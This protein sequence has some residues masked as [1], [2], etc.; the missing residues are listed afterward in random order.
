[1]ALSLAGSPAQAQSFTVS[2]GDTVGQQIMGGVGDSGHVQLGGQIQT[3]GI[4]ETAVEMLASGQSLLN[5]GTISTTGDNALGIASNMDNVTITNRGTISTTG[6]NAAGIISNGTNA[7][8]G[9]SGTISTTGS[10]AVGII[11]VDDDVLIENGG[12]ISTTGFSALGIRSSG[13]DATLANSGAISTTGTLAD[14]ISS[15]GANAAITN[16]DTIT[17]TGDGSDGINSTGADAV[18]TNSGEISTAGIGAAGI[19]SSLGGTGATITNSGEISTTGDGG[20]GISSGAADAAIRNSGTITTTGS[21]AG[22]IT[23][24]VDAAN[25]VIENSGT[26]STTG[27]FAYGISSTGINATITSSGSISTTA[28]AVHSIR[29]AGADAVIE[30][31]GTISTSGMGAHGIDSVAP[32]AAITNSGTI[33]TTGDFSYALHSLGNNAAITNSGTLLTHGITAHGIVSDGDNT[34]ISN[35]G[36]LST[37]ADGA[38]AIL[39][40]GANTL[41]EN[42][43]TVSTTADGA[44]ALVSNNSDVVIRNSGTIST[45]G[46]NTDAIA[47]IGIDAVIVN[48]G[49]ISA[50]GVNSYAVWASGANAV[51]T[52][53]GTIT[54]EQSFSIGMTGQN[55]T[56]NL[57]RGSVLR[58]DIQFFNLGSATLNIGPGLSTALQLD[59]TPATITTSGMPFAVTVDAIY[60]ADVTA[61]GSEGEALADL[62]GGIFSAIGGRR[63]G[64]SAAVPLAYAPEKAPQTAIFRTDDAVPT[65]EAWLKGFGGVRDEDGSGGSLGYDQ[66]LAGFV[67]GVD[68]FA[69]EA[70]TAGVFLGGSWGQ[71][72]VALSQDIEALSAFGGVYGTF[73]LGTA[74][75]DLAFAAG[76]SSYDSERRVNNS[77]VGLE[78]AEADYDGWFVSPHLALTQPFVIGGQIVEAK[79]SVHYAGLFLDGYEETGSAANLNVDERDVHLFVGRAGLSVPVAFAHAGGGL[80]TVTP[81]LGVEGRAQF[82]DSTATGSFMGTDI[83]LDLDDGETIGGFAGLKIEHET[84]A[85][86]SFFAEAEG[87]IEDDASR[88]FAKGGIRARF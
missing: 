61:I 6:A 78:T 37:T 60:T 74:T 64:A 58:G 73:G 65:R 9:N 11:S 22:G 30:N 29:S 33:S 51:I 55:A 71:T 42:S 4:A 79:A 75:L 5:E 87:L 18:I 26:I 15:A 21:G 59:G 39:S 67:S 72:D 16:T 53:S 48:S 76:F 85:G 13:A 36:T 10:S 32:D 47:S 50:T 1:L 12:T 83:V 31:S 66:A 40:S 49:T 2:S 7:A 14:G 86:L 20:T 80:T 81:S 88:F 23:S 43:G 24:S 82:G 41:I 34:V 52:N 62:T 77:L 45:Q 19:M 57:L 69:S 46:N 56:L 25:A 28:D 38:W 70:G 3:N 35:S 84:A 27:F 8:I 17:T 63:S 68:V 44:V 54:S